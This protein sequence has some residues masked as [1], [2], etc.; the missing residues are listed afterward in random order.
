M[1]LIT[2][3]PPYSVLST[4]KYNIDAYK[5][6]IT[7]EGGTIP[8]EEKQKKNLQD[9]YVKF[10]RFA[11]LAIT[12]HKQGIVG[13]ICPN[14]FADNVTFRGM[15]SHLLKTYDYIWFINLHGN[16]RKKETSPE[17]IEPD[18]NVFEIM[19]GICIVFFIRTTHN[20]NNNLPIGKIFQKDIWGS[21][22]RK[23]KVLTEILENWEIILSSVA[24]H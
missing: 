5:S 4:S 20:K 14:G 8:L 7:K 10:I 16:K 18:E 15:R 19:Q 11:E 13:I 1:L 12:K 9:D 22:Q 17:G 24:K 21:R 2:G 3:N 23:S 6:I